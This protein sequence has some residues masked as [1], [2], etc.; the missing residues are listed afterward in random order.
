MWQAT[1]QGAAAARAGKQHVPLPANER[2]SLDD[3]AT[4]TPAPDNPARNSAGW[5]NDRGVN[6]ADQSEKATEYPA[7][8]RLS[9]RRLLATGAASVSFAALPPG[10]ASAGTTRLTIERRS[11]D[12]NGRPAMVFGIR[13]DSGAVGIALDPGQRFAV[14]LRNRAGV[15]TI[16]HWHGQI[17]PVRQDGVTQTGLET[18]IPAGADQAYDYVPRPGT[19]W[20]HSHHGLQEQQ[21]MAAPLVVRTRADLRADAQEV[22]VLLQDFTFRDPQEILAGLRHAGMAMRAPAAPGGSRMAGMATTL[23]GGRAMPDAAKFGAAMSGSGMR[24]RSDGS[25]AGGMDLNDVAYDAFLANDRTLA[26]PEVVRT[27]RGGQ[28]RLR[29]INGAA[30]TAFWID[31]GALDGTVVAV[32][33]DPVHP[34]AVRRVPIAEAQ[35]VDVL[36]RIPAGGGAFPVLAQREGDRPRTGIVLATPGATVRKLLPDAQAAAGPVDLSL[37]R[38]LRARFPLAPRRPDLVYRVA[39]TGQM[40]P[41]IWGIDGRTWSDRLPLEVAQGKRV[42]FDLVNRTAMAHPMHL[43]G[44]HF[45]VQALNGVRFSGA[46]R[47]TVLVPIGG[48]VRIAFDADSPGRWLFHCHNLYHM[49]SGMMTEVAYAGFKGGY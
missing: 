8:W 38:R 17:P 49:A 48:T 7:P 19:Y 18:L 39:L 42:A 26:D 13:Q 35:R 20:M 24:M 25:A 2:T 33:G 47:D 40:M 44:H 10:R 43:H 6:A 12:V 21:L 30:A 15:P 37:E 29:L 14:D 5:P 46:M 9:R 3:P 45:Q 1:K 11:L 16:I 27:E 4:G 23:E 32:D 34:V 31:L 36:L 41:F 22:T 28:V